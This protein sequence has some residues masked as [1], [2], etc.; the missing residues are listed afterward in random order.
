MTKICAVMPVLIE[1]EG[2]RS[3]QEIKITTP[4]PVQDTGYVCR[5]EF[6]GASRYDSEF[7][8]SDAISALNL[9]IVFMNGIVENSKEPEFFW[10]N[11][12]TMFVDHENK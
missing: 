11:G 7:N 3:R 8:A 4:E 6:S 10:P 5:I 1:A 12:D 9:V 2:S